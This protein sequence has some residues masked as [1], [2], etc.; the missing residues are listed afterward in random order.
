MNESSCRVIHSCRVESSVHSLDR[1]GVVQFE[2]EGF[3]CVDRSVSDF[4]NHEFVFNRTISLKQRL[5][6]KRR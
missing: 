6:K 3:F 2:R 5:E 1:G 4:L